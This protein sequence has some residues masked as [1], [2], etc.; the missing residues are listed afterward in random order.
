ML[1]YLLMSVE[2]KKIPKIREEITDI[3][4]E[5]KQGIKKK[6]NQ[7]QEVYGEY[8]LLAK[9]E[10]N[11][12]K[13]MNDIINKVKNINGIQFIKTCSVIHKTRESDRLR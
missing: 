1:T 13:E 7:V 4:K 6:I 3:D 8:D 12:E 10:T 5:T 11:N 9:I 2:Q